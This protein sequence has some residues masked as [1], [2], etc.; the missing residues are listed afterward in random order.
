MNALARQELVG[1]G[2][3]LVRGDK[4]LFGL[5][6]GAHGGG[7]WSFPGGHADEGES[8]KASALR[9]LEEETGLQ[10]ANPLL[11]GETDDI[12]PGDLRYRTYFVRVDWAGGAPTLR[13]P[14]ACERW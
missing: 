5:R 11:V 6:R 4:V 8:P 1:V 14:H 12:F 3:I 7:T 2:V 10:G 9:E 13:E